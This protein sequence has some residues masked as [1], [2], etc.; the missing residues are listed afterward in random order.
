MKPR[1]SVVI[2]TFHRAQ[3][4]GRCLAAVLAQTLQPQ[5]FEVIVVYWR[6]RGAARFRVFFL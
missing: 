2:P 4:L 3:L 1:L 5:A 6:L